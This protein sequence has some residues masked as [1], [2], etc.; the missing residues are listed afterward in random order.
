MT[1]PRPPVPVESKVK[2]STVGAYVGA[3]AG[4]FVLELIAA[5]PVIVTPM[6]DV[7]E[8]F[9]LAVLPALIALFGGWKAAHTPRPDLPM[10]DR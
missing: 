3:S 2:W 7:L 8:P 1:A 10:R 4:L 9:V 5:E 6:P